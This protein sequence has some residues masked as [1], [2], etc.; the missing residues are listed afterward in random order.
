MNLELKSNSLSDKMEKT[1]DQ[2]QYL[3]GLLFL[4]PNY[5]VVWPDAR[6][7][8]LR[9]YAIDINQEIESISKCS[10]HKLD[11][12]RCYINKPKMALMFTSSQQ[13]W[14]ISSKAYQ[15]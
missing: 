2:I 1:R 7:I 10:H 4:W 5:T 8:P 14:T 9:R 13:A 11:C 6:K 12:H 15:C 3:K